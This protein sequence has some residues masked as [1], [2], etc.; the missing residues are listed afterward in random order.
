MRNPILN[1]VKKIPRVNIGQDGKLVFT[2]VAQNCEDSN[3]SA[4][5][6]SQQYMTTVSARLI[7]AIAGETKAKIYVLHF[8]GSKNNALFARLDPRIEIISALTDDFGYV[9]RD[10]I[11]GFDPHPGPYWHYAI[12]RLLIDRVN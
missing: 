6:P 1:Q 5:D 12:S 2:L 9:M 3:C 10:D 4:S 8:D 11:E 7:N